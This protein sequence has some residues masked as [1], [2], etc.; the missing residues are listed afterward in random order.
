MMSSPP[1]LFYMGVTPGL[2][3]MDLNPNRCLK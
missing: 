1:R 3:S 2:K